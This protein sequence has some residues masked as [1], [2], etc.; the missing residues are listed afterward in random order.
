MVVASLSLAG[1][2]RVEIVGLK[3]IPADV[4]ETVEQKEGGTCQSSS[5]AC[6]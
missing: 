2:V 1:D 6:I 5:K 3:V 4:F